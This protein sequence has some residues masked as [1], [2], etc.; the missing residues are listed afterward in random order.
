MENKIT[1][2]EQNASEQSDFARRL[3]LIAAA[4]IVLV[5]GGGIAAIAYFGVSRAQVS[6]DNAQVVAPT[7]V[8]SASSAGTLN[9]VYVSAGDTV[10]PNTVVA[11]VGTELLKATSGG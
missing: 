6:I 3:P 4:A 2:T 11:E 7:A 8:L 5:V 1:M 9:H 10:L